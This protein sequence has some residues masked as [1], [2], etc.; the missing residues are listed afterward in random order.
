M[1]ATGLFIVMFF[2]RVVF[3]RWSSLRAD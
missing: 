2:E 3:S 1:I